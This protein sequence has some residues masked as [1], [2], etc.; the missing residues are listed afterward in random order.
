MKNN[1][2]DNILLDLFTPE[3]AEAIGIRPGGGLTTERPAELT[4]S[5][6]ST[7]PVRPTAEPAFDE[8]QRAYWRTL[9]AFFRSGKGGHL[10]MDADGA[11]CYP[12][13]LAPYRNRPHMERNFPLW[14]E[15][16]A[17]GQVMP[18]HELLTERIAR[19]APGEG[20]AKILK[21]NLL[22]LEVIVR[23]KVQFA[24]DAYQAFSV[25]DDALETLVERLNI[26]GT[27]GDIFAN[28]VN[29]LRKHIPRQGLLV[30]FSPNVPFYLL[31]ALVR[32]HLTGKRKILQE[33]IGKL[34]ARLKE[35]LAVEQ[36]KK[37][38]SHSADKLQ[39]A[40]D[41][42]A[43][44]FNFEELSSVIPTGGSAIM[45]E[46]RLH[47][48]EKI[49]SL[50]E[51]TNADFFQKNACLILGESLAAN[52]KVDWEHAF[53]KCTVLVA[54]PG[55]DCRLAMEIFDK[56]MAVYAGMFA[57]IRTAELEV[58]DKYT[59]EIHGDFFAHFDWR[60]FT[61]EEMAVCP[62]VLLFAK[63]KALMESELNEFSQLLSSNRPVKMLVLKQGVPTSAT[64]FTY[65]QE[66]GAMAV[67]HR[68]AYVLQS[69][70]VAPGKLVEGFREGLGSYA[71]ALFHIFSPTGEEQTLSG[72]NLWTSAAVEGREFPGFVYNHEQGARWGSRFNILHNPQPEDNWPQ[73]RLTFQN[74]S[75]DEMSLDLPFT[76]AD[77]AVQD[78]HY[79]GQ[80]HLVPPQFWTDD[81]VPLGD[82][83][84]L[85]PAELYA[86]VPCVWVVDE[87]NN[88]QKA[89]VAWPLVLT[90]QERLDFWHF[91]QENAG[92]HSYHVEQA[93][94][95]LRQEMEAEFLKK[96]ADL[97]AAH[98][99]ELD[100]A[101]EE[102]G[103][104]AM[105]RLAAVLLDLDT[106]ELVATPSAPAKPAKAAPTPK[107]EIP[108]SET[109]QSEIPKSEIENP[110]ILSLGEPWI[111]TPLCT[112][113]NDCININKR[114]FSYDANKQAFIADPKA[115]SFREL[116]LAAEKCP[117]S[118]IHPGAPGNAGEPGLEELVKRAERFQ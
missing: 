33:K 79:T 29:N 115:G 94:G 83:L 25:I 59:P 97:Q 40:L 93:T 105:E 76:F 67:A 38:E 103:R 77:F 68:N 112:S 32:N 91:L 70:S 96:T 47:R 90:C 60:S 57:A 86:K 7:L 46:E 37:P 41:F 118:I 100:K 95:R 30:P 104:V 26:G 31:A 99:T 110:E 19:S 114:L 63:D 39:G 107:S 42:A 11:H 72:P 61:A 84:K 43:S 23:E 48:I 71:P 64:G 82:Y 69:A 51:D 88:L 9:R 78:A 80:F 27:E 98:A 117:V 109:P 81:L 66:L 5:Q 44:Y 56:K 4:F 45:P 58:D 6:A 21:D 113:C 12:A 75:G 14:M 111:D 16:E 3:A 10:P 35:I 34:T 15:E 53:E 24:E 1:Q 73:H 89:A 28:D 13:L 17:G 101:K 116:V 54:P 85:P 106:S 74:E 102:E 22:R 36:D 87:K 49:V 20:D 65:R 2:P 55:R 92:V 50:L 8:E 62:P 18:L 52:A 108:K